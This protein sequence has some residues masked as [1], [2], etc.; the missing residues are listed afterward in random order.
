MYPNSELQYTRKPI[1]IEARR[2]AELQSLWT[3]AE[4]LM[5]SGARV[6]INESEMTLHY[7][8]GSDCTPGISQV[9]V[10][11]PETSQP[12][13]PETTMRIVRGQ[14]IQ[15][16]QPPT[17]LE[18]LRA[19][20]EQYRQLGIKYQVDEEELTLRVGFQLFQFGGQNGINR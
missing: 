2:Q 14:R 3:E 6:T 11:Q 10:Q 17:P 4:A 1:D 16:P 8:Y 7:K 12:P 9:G 5:R 20:A 19:A 18:Q 15:S 13:A